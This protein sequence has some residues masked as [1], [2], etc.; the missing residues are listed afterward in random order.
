MSGG[1]AYVSETAARPTIDDPAKY[2]PGFYDRLAA[3]IRETAE[4]A[5]V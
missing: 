4:S 1:E 3:L 2:E 5:S